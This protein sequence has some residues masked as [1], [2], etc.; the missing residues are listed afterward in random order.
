MDQF[1]A[2]LDR[3]WDLVSRGDTRGAAIS[4]RRALELDPNSPEVFNLL[5]YICAADGEADEALEH[6]RQAMALD[7]GYMEPILNAAEIL[8]HPLREYDEAVALCED[9]LSFAEEIEEIVDAKLLKFDALVGKGDRDAARKVLAE[10]PEGPYPNPGYTYL[11]GRAHYEI[12]QPATARGFIEETVERDP[13]NADAR[14][15][16]GLILD[17][18]GD[19]MGA[20]RAFLAAR[21]LDLAAGAP[22]WS[23]A[24]D[25]FQRLVEAA[26]GRLP[27]ELRV[28]MGG[29]LVVVSDVPGVE[30][31]A[32]GVDPR[33]PVLVDV[34]PPPVEP[35]A[36]D[37]GTGTVERADGVAMRGGGGAGAA[38]ALPPLRVFVYQRCLERAAGSLAAVEDTLLD[39][40]ERE[41]RA[42]LGQV[43]SSGMG[44]PADTDAGPTEPTG[45]GLEPPASDD[46]A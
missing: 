16:L 45:E 36:G 9:A 1:T 46:Q 12:G 30:V 11:V 44:A 15:Y 4:A 34:S 24:D 38:A 33:I 43:P 21:A 23:P 42:V 37:L 28:A 14:Y 8:V 7:D 41:L 3:G 32:E 29:A 6:Y 35:A 2:H 39:A 40:L 26:T 31:V 20:T 27:A 5:G 22:E 10:I 18:E 13:A 19:P 17:D 25:A